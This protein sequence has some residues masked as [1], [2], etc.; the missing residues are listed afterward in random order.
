MVFVAAVSILMAAAGSIPGCE[1]R[2]PQAASPKTSPPASHDPDHDHGAVTLLGERTIGSF[3]VKASRD[4]DIKAGGDAAI[5]VWVSGGSS[6]VAA[7][8]F[9]IGTE[10]AKGSVK[11]KAEIEGDHWHTHAEV[12]NP[13]PDG[14][15]L[16]VEIE[17][18]GGEKAAG[19]FEL[20][21]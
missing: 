5:D 12:P 15:K 7:V 13:I 21:R 8:R 9:W 3:T 19:S 18:E 6:K 10:E 20:K 11:A 16:W 2:A 1:E 4:G 17:A 14:S